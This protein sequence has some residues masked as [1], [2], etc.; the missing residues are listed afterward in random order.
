MTQPAVLA[1]AL[2]VERSGELSESAVGSTFTYEAALSNTSIV[3]TTIK[4]M[5]MTRR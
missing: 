2:K 5:M 4:V 1:P 3:T